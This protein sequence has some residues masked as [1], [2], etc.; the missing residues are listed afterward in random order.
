V[1]VRSKAGNVC[2]KR[3][4][5][6][7]DR[8]AFGT[9]RRANSQ[10]GRASA[11]AGPGFGLNGRTFDATWEHLLQPGERIGQTGEHP[12]RTAE[13]PRRA[14]TVRSPPSA[15]AARSGP[16]SKR[17]IGFWPRI[18]P[19]MQRA[20]L[21]WAIEAQHLDVLTLRIQ[22]PNLGIARPRLRRGALKKPQDAG[23]VRHVGL[24]ERLGERDRAG[25]EIV[26]PN[27]QR[28]EPLQPHR[29]RL[30]GRR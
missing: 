21:T 3:E 7:S 2:R 25:E 19:H 23:K 12:G 20:R 13:R 1:P 24:F 28:P 26:A 27:R 17:R 8:K 10:K 30:A 5:G 14:I 18:Y 29:P 9:N 22:H 16:A 6:G 4:K 11:P 15:A